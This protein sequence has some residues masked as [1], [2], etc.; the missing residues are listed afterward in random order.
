MLSIERP[1]S[2][3][4]IGPFVLH[5]SN[6]EN[7]LPAMVN[8][9]HPSKACSTC[10]I[11]KVKCD[12][13]HPTCGN[14]VKSKRIC[15][16]YQNDQGRKMTRRKAALGE[17][18][19]L[20]IK[21]TLPI[22]RDYNVVKWI[23]SSADAASFLENYLFSPS[24]K[25]LP[26]NARPAVLNAMLST[27]DSMGIG[28]FTIQTIRQCFY[29]LHA[30]FQTLNTRRTLLTSYSSA[31]TGLTQIITTTANLPTLLCPIFLFALY[32]VS[33]KKPLIIDITVSYLFRCL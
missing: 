7:G 12:L 17:T 5:F 33:H 21:V 2:S 25:V 4:T 16:G 22:S 1:S 6:P 18:K 26:R 20:C 14:C 3:A 31:M 29:S 8:P 15:L 23:H 27:S 30:E 10:K 24:Q 9:G 28:D 13:V 11:R 32:E 19:E